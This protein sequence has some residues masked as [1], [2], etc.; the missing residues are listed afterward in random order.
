V[1]TLDADA[2]VNRDFA[3]VAYYRQLRYWLSYFAFSPW[4][5]GAI[6]LLILI[7]TATRLTTI[8]FGVFTGGF[9][10]SSVEVLLLISFQIIYGYVYQV[11]GLIIT[12]FMAGLAVG[13]MYG[14]KMSSK[15]RIVQYI[16]VQCCIGVYCLL[17]P[18]VL[19]L[20]KNAS[21]SSTL[22]YAAFSLLAS[23]IGVLIGTEFAIATRLVKEK[24]SVI[25][26][27]LYGIDL[28]GSAI[29]ALLISAY[30]LPLLGIS[31]AFMVIAFL[32]FSSASAAIAARK[33]FAIQPTEELSYV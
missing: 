28:L 4:I 29:G 2:V 24:V 32:S 22:I 12:V 26:S 7:G 21:E 27:E 13:S 31:N 18:M 10:A 25:A 14:Q 17:L 30:L 19:S 20:L 6:G 11:T 1:K 9:T 3:P 15:N 33:R 8:S 16:A 5:P 23:G